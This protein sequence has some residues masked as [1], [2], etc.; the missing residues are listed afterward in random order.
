MAL[1]V[2]V[3]M[4]ALM[5]RSRGWT[6]PLGNVAEWVAGVGA[7]AAFVAAFGALLYT[8]R[9]W[10]AAQAERRGREADQARLI[11]AEPAEPAELEPSGLPSDEPHVVVRNHSEAPVFNVVAKKEP[12]PGYTVTHHVL[13][14]G[15]YTSPV[16]VLAWTQIEDFRITFTDARGRPWERMGSGPPHRPS[17][18]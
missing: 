7:V 6:V 1:A 10:Q 16:R 15:A 11:V 8:A 13:K 17:P 4:Q 12:R 5:L 18:S 14:P 3:V 9:E 2:V